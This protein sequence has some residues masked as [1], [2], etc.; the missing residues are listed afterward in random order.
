MISIEELRISD[1]PVLYVYKT[2][3][4][5]ENRPGVIMMHGLNNDKENNLMF[6]YLIARK[7]YKVFLPDAKYHGERGVAVTEEV[8]NIKTLDTIMASIKELPFIKD[9]MVSLYKVDE[10]DITVGGL[11]MGAVTTFAAMTQYYWIKRAF[12]LMGT[13]YFAKLLEDTANSL[14]PEQLALFPPLEELKKNVAHIDLSSQ[15]RVVNGRDIFAWHGEDDA[16]VDVNGILEFAESLNE[17]EAK[18]DIEVVIESNCGH[19]ISRLC[20]LSL[21]KWFD[22]YQDV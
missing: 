1:V 6:A 19:K 11:S 7:G 18:H 21:L 4:R 5:D 14:T 8:R 15:I 20:V 12:S 16:V 3:L 13:P 10:S 9:E 2:D 17:L 22:K